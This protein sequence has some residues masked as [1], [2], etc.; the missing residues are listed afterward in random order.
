MQSLRSGSLHIA[1]AEDSPPE[2]VRLSWLGKSNDRHPERFLEPYFAEIVGEAARRHV[3]IEMHF[4]HLSHF[5]SSTIGF[6]VQLIQ[7]TQR[8]GVKL[9]LVFNETLSWQRVS[10]DALRVLVKD[11]AMLSLQGAS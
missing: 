8:R 6:L 2:C 3:G 9:T 11:D 5:N 10:F 4:E 1:V 7:E